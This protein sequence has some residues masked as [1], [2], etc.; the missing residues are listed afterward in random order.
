MK[1]RPEVDGLRT[2]AVL[3]VL[4]YHAEFSFA[5]KQLF[6]GGYLGVDI[7][8]VISGY[9]ITSLIVTEYRDTGRFSVLGFYERR[10]RRLKPALITVMLTAL[11]VAWVILLPTQLIDF[12]K[13]LISSLFFVSNFYWH[14]TLQEYGAESALLKPFLHT[15]SLA[16]EEQYYLIFPLLIVG[17][18]RYVS[19]YVIPILIAGLIAS[20]ISAEIVNSSDSS[21][22]FYML[23]TRFW[24]LLSGALIA[25][26]MMDQKLPV[27][28]PKPQRFAMAAGLALISYSLVFIEF[29]DGHPGFV[30]LIPVLG[31][32]LIISFANRAD[33]VTRL[34]S[35]RPFVSIGLMSYS[36]YLWHYPIFA[37][38]RMIERSPDLYDKS[39]W[40]ALS[41][42]LSYLT[43]R[44]IELP[45]RNRKRIAVR[46]LVST[47]IPT[48]SVVLIFSIYTIDN[49]GIKER[50]P[51]LIKIYTNN[52]FD[53]NILKE[54]SKQILRGL[55]V[56]SGAE[57]SDLFRKTHLWFSEEQRTTKVL[58][59]GNSHSKDLFNAF[60]QNGDLYEDF[61]FARYY[62]QID[63]SPSDLDAFISSPNFRHADIIFISTRYWQDE[64][65]K[66]LTALPGFLER[67]MLEEKI[68]Y[69]AS[70]TVEFEHSENVTIFDRIIRDSRGA[71]TQDQINREYFK[72]RTDRVLNVN[73]EVRNIAKRMGIRYLEKSDYICDF[74]REVCTGITD[75]DFKVFYDYGHYTLEG[76]RY[77]GRRI[78]ELGWLD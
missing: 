56:N 23:P 45:F 11:P 46:P 63:S 13:S 2:I 38:G 42:L 64:T 24:E 69:L 34:L 74:D 4:F 59:A 31:T 14:G 3:S 47:L 52:E 17:I 49:G 8:F 77:F 50:F 29:S 78:F 44:F 35:S 10:I 36:L 60:Y 39:L 28:E 55:A 43:F 6:V 75:D 48:I 16:V 58:V 70:N 41:A 54:E 76:A 1:Y 15:W 33:P 65:R 20:L 53:N 22:A 25:I 7:F 21:F 18:Y 67:L 40:F 27:L 12:S 32:V 62:I 26:L 73:R 61:E 37:F 57:S 68:I 9:L 19:R 71:F 30:T 5:G 51:E 66:D 72:R